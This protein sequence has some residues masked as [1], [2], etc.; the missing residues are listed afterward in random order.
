MWGALG[1]VIGS[2]VSASVLEFW[3]PFACYLMAAAFTTLIAVNGIFLNDELEN[4]TFALMLSTEDLLYQE[5]LEEKRQKVNEELGF[6][7]EDNA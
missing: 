5:K 7:L 1:L 3:N 4:N 6:S 2:V